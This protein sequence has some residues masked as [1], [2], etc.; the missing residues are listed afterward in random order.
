[1]VLASLTL[2]CLFSPDAFAMKED[3]MKT[4][5]GKL[6]GYLTGNIARGAVIG[7]CSIA[8]YRAYVDSKF[9]ILGAAVAG[10]LGLNFLMDFVNA[11]YACLI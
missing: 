6:E 3:S 2:L 1:L 9:G 5:L 10:A 8:A 4:G 7:G 11:T